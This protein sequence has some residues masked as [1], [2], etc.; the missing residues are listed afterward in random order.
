[1]VITCPLLSCCTISSPFWENNNVVVFPFPFHISMPLANLWIM[2]LKGYFLILRAKSCSDLYPLNRLPRRTL[3]LGRGRI[4][5]PGS[6]WFA[7][8]LAVYY[9]AHS[10][11]L[12]GAGGDFPFG[13]DET[14][15]NFSYL[16]ST[17]REWNSYSWK[18]FRLKVVQCGPC[19]IIWNILE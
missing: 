5:I 4:P 12:G 6:I 11:L 3:A 16:S 9:V 17:F 13:D 10:I 15:R 8:A 18:Y 19:I 7:P 14:R 2:R 1:M